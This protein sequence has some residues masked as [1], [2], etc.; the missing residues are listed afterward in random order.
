[1][2]KAIV[3]WLVPIVFISL[4]VMIG[5]LNVNA[6]QP[7]R[8]IIP[9]TILDESK[10]PPYTLPDPMICIDGTPV[11]DA[12]TWWSKRRPEILHLCEQE[13]FGKTPAGKPANMKF[14]VRNV[15]KDARG[16]KATRIRVAVLFDGTE[17]GPQ[18]ELLIYLPNK[19]R[20]KVPV[21]LALNFDGNFTTTD[22]PDIPVPHH[23]ATGLSPNKVTDNKTEET[24]RGKLAASWPYDF[25][26]Q[27]GFGIA[28]IAY[29][30]IE[31]DYDGGIKAG[32]RGK[33]KEF[34][35]TNSGG[36]R[37]GAVGA[38]AWA[39]SRAMDYLE[40]N[41]R[42][43]AKRIAVQ[44]H[45]RLGKAAL[46]AVAQDNRFA[47]ALSNESGAGG[48][49]LNRRIFGETVGDL[50]R[51][52]PHWFCP[53]FSKYNENE[54]ALPVDSHEL[55]ALIAPRPVLITSAQDDHWS[56][57][58]AE[59]LAGVGADPVYRLLCAD[60]ISSHEWPEPSNLLMGR[61]GYFMRPGPHDVRIEDWQAYISFAERYFK[62]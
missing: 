7:P 22:E 35:Q 41:P 44:G 9:A 62:K 32:Y 18:M 53:N 17:T 37:M 33:L 42:V 47:M 20:S 21:I 2:S 34:L 15:K 26:L 19:A 3:V 50:N 57:P 39:L 29:G 27:H 60:G 4:S 12:K 38:W 52:F 48:A 61:I 1:M 58:K 55:I 14:V 51:R 40:T 10:V 11:K 28:T 46:W 16:G 25:A 8:P 45:S 6:Q 5:L 13:W 59:F 36:D 43:D 56:D 31:P 23:W 30:D 49:A 54:E 24:S